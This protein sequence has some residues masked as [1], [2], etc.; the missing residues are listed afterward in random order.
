M[1]ANPVDNHHSFNKCY[2]TVLYS[3]GDSV[4]IIANLFGFF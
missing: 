3:S 2:E 1:K 4:I